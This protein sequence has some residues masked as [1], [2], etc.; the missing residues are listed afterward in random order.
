[1]ILLR[2]LIIFKKPI[3]GLLGFFVLRSKISP[4]SLKVSNCVDLSEDA[5]KELSLI[6]LESFEAQEDRYS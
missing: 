1:M 4:M 3:K 5:E 6:V 2:R